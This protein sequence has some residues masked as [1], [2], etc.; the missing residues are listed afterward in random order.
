MGRFSVRSATVRDDDGG[1]VLGPAG[2]TTEV[3]A[4]EIDGIVFRFGDCFAAGAVGGKPVAATVRDGAIHFDV[5]VSQSDG[6]KRFAVEFP[7]GSA[8]LPRT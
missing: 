3:G 6:Y 1:P 8:R 2:G 4:H 7:A 5:A